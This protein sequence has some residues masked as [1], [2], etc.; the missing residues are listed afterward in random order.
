M[1]QNLSGLER[2]EYIWLRM[3]KGDQNA[4]KDLYQLYYKALFNFG[5]KIA[6]DDQIIED[7]VQ[8][9]F[10][11]I[12][13]YRSS[14]N[15]PASVKQYLF[16]IF[17]NH[18]VRSFNERSKITYAEEILNFNFEVGFDKKMI[19]GEDTNLVAERINKAISQLTDRQRE[20]I[21]FRFFENLSFEEISEIMGMQRRATYKLTARA[22]AALKDIL[23]SKTFTIFVL[24]LLGGLS[25]S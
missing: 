8:E 4:L 23:D 15:V 21:Y 22:L 6:V 25:N 7:A 2:D 9:A 5:Q 19:E 1:S 20:I 18:L 14:L 12:W 10:I 11:S 16:K 3:K 24:A 13:K 17:R